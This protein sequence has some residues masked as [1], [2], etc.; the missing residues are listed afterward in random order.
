M[1]TRP[2]TAVVTDSI[3][4]KSDF[5][6]LVAHGLDPV[7]FARERLG[8]E[9]DEW[10]AKMLR[11]PARQIILCNGRQVG[12]SSIAALKALHVALYQ[13]NSL[14]ILIAPSLRQ[15]REL[16]LKFVAFMEMLEPAPPPAEEFNK[17][18]ITLQ[19]KSRVV[20]LPGDNPRA[21]RGFSSP[22]LILLDEAAFALDATWE[23]L[24]PMMAVS[25]GQI[26][27]C[28]TPNLPV[29]FFHSIWHGSGDWERYFVPT[30]ECPRISAGWLDEKKRDNPLTF[31]REYE[32]EWTGSEDGLFTAE[33]L[34]RCVAHDFEP[35]CAGASL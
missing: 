17:L 8:F 20:C 31:A 6:R 21:V 32:C 15:S 7:L 25:A 11:S 23:A 5:A 28:S 30:R 4:A 35:F 9:P 13:P 18:S 29:G 3:I 34:D 12:K 1:V 26:I 14:T 19:N 10:Q 22:A 24:E 33:M 16:A 27:L 2:T